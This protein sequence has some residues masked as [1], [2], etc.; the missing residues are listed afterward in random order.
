MATT[1]KRAAS[2]ATA[3][4]SPVFELVQPWEQAQGASALDRTVK[5]G[6]ERQSFFARH[7]EPPS[8]VHVDHIQQVGHAALHLT[9]RGHALDAKQ[10][11]K[12]T[13]NRAADASSS[14]GSD[15]DDDDAFESKMHQDE[16]DSILMS[17][18]WDTRFWN[19][20][21]IQEAIRTLYAEIEKSRDVRRR[22][23]A[24]K[25]LLHLNSI[26][27][28]AYLTNEN[29]LSTLANRAFRKLSPRIA[30]DA[31]FNM[32][33]LLA[34]F[35]EPYA[36]ALAHENAV[37]RSLACLVRQM[38]CAAR[39][40]QHFRRR[41]LFERQVKLQDIAVESRMR[42]RA[43][44]IAKTIELSRQQRLIHDALGGAPMPERA[45]LA[46]MTIVVKLVK[47]ELNPRQGN[48]PR[49]DRAKIIPAGGLVWLNRCVQTSGAVQALAIQLLTVLAHDRDRI[50][51][52]LQSNVALYVSK[53]LSEPCA[54]EADKRLA[55]EFFD[56]AALS[57]VEMV[58]FVQ[59][60][61]S[62]S[63]QTVKKE[64]KRGSLH[65]ESTKKDRVVDDVDAA[66]RNRHVTMLALDRLL[67]VPILSSL[68]NSLATT[69]ALARETLSVLH[70]MAFETGFYVLLDVVTRHGGRH[71]ES[72]VNCLASSDHSV[73]LAA[74]QVLLALAARQEGRDGLVVA[75]L[76]V[77]VEPF[78]APG[79]RKPGNSY[80]FVVGLLTIVTCANPTNTPLSFSRAL[81]TPEDAFPPMVLD[82]SPSDLLNDLHQ[83]LLHCSIHDASGMSAQYFIKTQT[84]EFVLDL[85]VERP[86]EASKQT[87]SQRHISAIV[88]A[89]LARVT[90]IAAALA[91]RQDVTT[92]LALVVQANGMDQSDDHAMNAVDSQRHL[93]STAGVCNALIR[94]I[95]S[96]T[97]ESS[98]PSTSDPRLLCQCHILRTLLKLHALEDVVAFCRPVNSVS[99]FIADDILAVKGAI[100]LVGLLFPLQTTKTSPVG[101]LHDLG[102][103]LVQAA[104]PA[105]LR[106]LA[107]DDPLPRVVKW[108]C[109][110]LAQ[111]CMTNATCAHVVGLRSVDV[112]GGLIPNSP[113]DASKRI[114]TSVSECVEDDKLIGLPHTFYA[115]LATFCRVA[116]G[117]AA[118]F[119]LNVLPHILKR[120]HL[121]S[122]KD[123]GEFT[124]H[125]HQ[126]RS[127]VARLIA[128]MANENVVAIGN[129]NEL[130]L[131][132]EVHKIL[133]NMLTCPPDAPFLD[134]FLENALAAMSALAKDHNRCV[135]PIV[136]AG[137]IPPVAAFLAKWDHDAS[138]TI[139][140]LEGVVHVFWGC[141]QSSVASVHA[142]IK[143]SKASEHLLRISCSF[144][145]E[146][147]RGAAFRKKSVGEIAREALRHLSEFEA[148]QMQEPPSAKS[149]RGHTQASCSSPKSSST[150]RLPSASQEPAASVLPALP[151]TP[152]TPPTKP[153][154]EMNPLPTID[155]RSTRPRGPKPQPQPAT[156]VFI[157]PKAKPVDERK[158]FPLLMLDPVFGALDHGVDPCKKHPSPTK[159]A[160]HGATYVGHEA[161]ILGHH[162]TVAAQSNHDEKQVVVVVPGLSGSMSTG[163]IHMQ[164]KR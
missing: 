113:T 60:S 54:D 59:I 47:D 145:L 51:D 42:V 150:S 110:A 56:R 134:S 80:R 79:F 53:I 11:K 101:D 157:R 41:R 85:L 40:L 115:L 99:D 70:K 61:T 67:T 129:L 20:V 24:Q 114:V 128:A 105:L 88:I 127:E 135:V 104:A 160:S 103:R 144:K 21:K 109:G 100:Q 153:A 23:L 154:I 118:I 22:Q 120:I 39:V 27:R 36:A 68:L 90:N 29:N 89:S 142:A 62:P 52:I 75:G 137:A 152:T 74:L 17:E 158:K 49:H 96:Q 97:L 69:P 86:G 50:T 119:R 71:L 14:S 123:T 117:R 9:A 65:R 94:F 111:F 163:K 159:A 77:L 136:S 98:S 106:T 87:R 155:W 122:S 4:K 126:C 7:H 112:L 15:D 83:W 93:Q 18:E 64:R 48:Y 76:V 140:M 25:M 26:H 102:L 147:L 28:E 84:L 133:A 91:F 57:V 138:V 8:A 161:T 5:V 78:C 19:R 139:P 162:V 143:A 132:H 82:V 12:A 58:L 3:S 2:A 55:L 35:A 38:D 107:A 116:D 95:Q 16:L 63:R 146:M 45:V 66:Y 124:L 130:F 6:R 73:V 37:T 141:S 151:Q 148:K 156:V 31:V 46:Y 33:E 81:A 34:V 13:L 30:N 32:A 164:S 125:D 92:H 72:I 44:N 43:I 1:R 10:S 131:R 108:C 121:A 149:C